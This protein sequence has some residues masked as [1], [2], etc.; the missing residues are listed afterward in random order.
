M[1]PIPLSPKS[2]VSFQN[3]IIKSIQKTVL[4]SEHLFSAL[5][6]IP[7]FQSHGLSSGGLATWLTD[8][9]YSSNTC[10]YRTLKHKDTNI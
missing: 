1:T 7:H 6:L 3:S 8:K 4:N 5:C 9:R 2:T 10:A